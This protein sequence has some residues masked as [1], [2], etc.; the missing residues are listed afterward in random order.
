MQQE[1]PT[2]AEVPRPKPW[3]VRAGAA[4]GLL[5]G[6]LLWWNAYRS[7]GG[8]LQNLQ[9]LFGP[10]VLGA[11]AVTVRNWVRKVGPFDPEVIAQNKQG[12][13]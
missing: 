1:P 3:K 6:V 13:V 8:I 12:R 5:V 10:V 4:I 11:A 2:D 7:G 9:L